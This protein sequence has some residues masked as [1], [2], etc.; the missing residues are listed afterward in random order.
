M[1]AHHQHQQRSSE[2]AF[3][4][5]GLRKQLHSGPFGVWV[6]AAAAGRART[7]TVAAVYF[8]EASRMMSCDGR[9]FLKV[10]AESCT[11]GMWG[12]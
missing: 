10:Q 8:A 1:Q 11:T 9:D 4:L 6:I 7:V 5:S 3:L 12:E 2:S